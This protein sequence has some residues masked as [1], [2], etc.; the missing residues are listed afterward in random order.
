MLVLV[1]LLNHPR[2]M[3][4]LILSVCV[5]LLLFGGYLQ[6]V[7]GLEPCPMCI[8]Q[9]YV[10]VLMALVAC[11]GLVFSSRPASLGVGSGLVLLAVVL[12][13]HSAMAGLRRVSGRYTSVGLA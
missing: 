12:L 2:R 11:L 13:L 9:R 4:W 6:H 5:G 10:M 8:V 7:V 1:K 3:W